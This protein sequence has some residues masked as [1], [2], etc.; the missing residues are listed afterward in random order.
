MNNL[1]LIWSP[2]S[3]STL[4]NPFEWVLNY[5]I[6]GPR[7]LRAPLVYGHL[8]GYGRQLYDAGRSIEEVLAVIMPLTAAAELDTLPDTTPQWQTASL[9]RAL[10]WHHT[11]CPERPRLLM[12]GDDRPSVEV[13]VGY[14]VNVGGVPFRVRCIYDQIEDEE[15]ALV[16]VER[17][18]RGGKVWASY[19]D[20][21][22]HSPQ[23]RTQML[24][25][26]LHL[27][28]RV[29]SPLPPRP[30]GRIKAEVLEAK[31]LHFEYHPGVT[32]PE[33]YTRTWSIRSDIVEEWALWVRGM[34]EWYL[35]VEEAGLLSVERWVE[36]L[37]PYT[38]R[39]YKSGYLMDLSMNRR[40]REEL[41]NDRQNRTS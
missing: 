21:L 32:I 34:L 39:Q 41:V 3:L 5:K 10:V 18:A 16:Y 40:S 27:Q 14:E 7:V 26:A 6:G 24:L 23:I 25:A 2:T 4:A 31:P 20:E 33:V 38:P 35:R 36:G 15:E 29:D 30:C 17:K 13:D 11:S 19:W 8:W 28:G 9:L 12:I 1:R 22:Y 37:V